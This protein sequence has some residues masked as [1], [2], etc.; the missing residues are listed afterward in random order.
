MARR[1]CFEQ[2]V[3]TA[4]HQEILTGLGAVVVE[5][6]DGT[7]RRPPLA[8]FGSCLFKVLPG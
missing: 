1:E 4:L 7:L 3:R 6:L 5:D 2:L 8:P